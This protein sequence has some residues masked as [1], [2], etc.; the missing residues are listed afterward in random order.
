[1]MSLFISIE[2][3]EGAG[4]TTQA[5]KLAQQLQVAGR[6]VLLTREPGGTSLGRRLRQVLLDSTL[7]INALAELL[8]YSASRAQLVD[9]QIGPALASHKVVVCDRFIDSTVAYQGAGRG[10]PEP[11]IDW[12]GT[13][14]ASGLVPDL[15]FLLD[16]DVK[17]GLERAQKRGPID[18]LEKESLNFHQR[19]REGFLQLA[20]Q[21]KERFVVLDGTTPPDILTQQIWDITRQ[22]YMPEL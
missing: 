20:E 8:L 21:N 7:Q 6:N 11:W 15:T 16:I 4:K 10:L 3:P 13:Q 5:Q 18:R 14:T 1:M 2:G 12:L 9:E 19:V 22:R 17:V